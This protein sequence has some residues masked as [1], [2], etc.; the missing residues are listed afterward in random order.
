VRQASL[1]IDKHCVS[2]SFVELVH[3]GKWY[4]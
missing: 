1:I 2:I 4:S 3:K